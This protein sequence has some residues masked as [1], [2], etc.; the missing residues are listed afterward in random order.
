[1]QDEFKEI[2]L[3]EHSEPIESSV[4]APRLLSIPMPA[5][6]IG[7]LGFAPIHMSAMSGGLLQPEGK[8][9]DLMLVA[10]NERDER[11]GVV[12]MQAKVVKWISVIDSL[13]VFLY[14]I[15]LL[16]PLLV[17]LPVSTIGFCAGRRLSRPLSIVQ[18]V[19]LLLC[20]ILR[21]VLCALVPMAA[22]RA[23]QGVL[24]VATFCEAIYFVKFYRTIGALS[25]TEVDELKAQMKSNSKP[26]HTQHNS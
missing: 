14:L 4:D 21:I 5:Y 24:V 23:V 7:N 22:F 20:F 10:T 13:A 17:L 8:G 12:L 2:Q 11:F 18:M 3:K 6:K 9:Q 15:A 16:Y 1:M 26:L 25:V 19:Y